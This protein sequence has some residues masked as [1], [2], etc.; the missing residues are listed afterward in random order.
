MIKDAQGIVVENMR[1]TKERYEMCLAHIEEERAALEEKIS[2]R[3]AE[4]VTLSAA[5][6]ELRS[7]A[8]TQVIEIVTLL[9][10]M[11]TSHL[12]IC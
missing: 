1:F 10:P 3:D 9:R 7:S 11:V 4:I 8:E 12:H 5:L 6:E 2:L